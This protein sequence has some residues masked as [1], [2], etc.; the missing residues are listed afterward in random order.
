MQ[1][2]LTACALACWLASV[3]ALP[4]LAA[5]TANPASS[6][7]QQF[8]RGEAALAQQRL[9]QALAQ[10]PGDASLRFLQGVILSETGQGA[11]AALLFERLTQ[12]FPG[13]PEPYN[14]LAVLQAAAGE[15]ALARGLLEAA[16]RLDPGY[17]TAQQNLGDVY[18]RLAQR[19]YEMAAGSSPEPGLQARLRL[20]REL[21]AIR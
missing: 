7:E 4:A 10:Q 15:L 11:E 18:V 9:A 3:V 5:E 19:A 14:N 16:L 6:I 12:D 21:A 8:R 13:L 1:H 20:A 17:R 2:L